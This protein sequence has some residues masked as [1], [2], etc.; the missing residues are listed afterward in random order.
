M[1]R[2]RS[3][4]GLACAMLRGA[5]LMKFS[6]LFAFMVSLVNQ[7]ASTSMTAWAKACGASCGR[8]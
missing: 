5:A 2:L 3:A 7:K 6:L 8:L 4:G 1:I